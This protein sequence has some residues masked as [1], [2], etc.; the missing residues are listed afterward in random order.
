MKDNLTDIE[1]DFLYDYWE[2]KFGGQNEDPDKESDSAG[3][4]IDYLTQEELNA[5]LL[6]LHTDSGVIIQ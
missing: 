5:L 3:E 1:T 4:W 2:D 6:P